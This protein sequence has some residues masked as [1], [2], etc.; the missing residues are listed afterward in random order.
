L[1]FSG[2]RT[3]ELLGEIATGCERLVHRSIREPAARLH[4]RRLI[5]LL[6]A[7]P[8]PVAVSIALTFPAQ[9]D[10]TTMLGAVC[11]TFAAGWL[12]ALAVMAT[13]RTRAVEILALVAGAGSA[14]AIVAAAGGLSS[15]A[16]LSIVALP[17]EAWWL[18]RSSKATLIGAAAGLAVIPV[19]AALGQSLPV[20]PDL[21]ALG[22]FV[23]LAYAAFAAPRAAAWRNEAATETTS[24]P[25]RHLDGMIDA[26][27]LTTTGSGDVIDASPQARRLLGVAPELLLADG[28]FERIHIADRVA[29]M[30]ALADLRQGDDKR[31]VE[32]RLRT[33][34]S[35]EG[36]AAPEYRPFLIE[37]M[38]QGDAEQSII[39][40]AR[41]HQEVVRLR[42]ALAAT[43]ETAQNLE[44]DKS[45]FLA[46]VS[47]ELR[48]PLNAI[49]GFSDMLLHGLFGAFSDPR[50]KEYVGLVSESGHHL[51]AVVNSILDVSRME[52]GTYSTAPEPFRFRDAVDM[53]HSMLKHQA[54]A[55]QI[56]LTV[57]VASE[58]GAIDA[59]RG[60]V[61][62]MLINLVSNAIK[63]T[64]DGGN[65][66]IGA[67]RIGS[68]LHF[69]VSDNGIGISADDLA[70]IGKPFTQVQNDYTKRYEGAGLGLSLVTGL[71]S[72]HQGTMSIESEPGNGTTVT[73]SL[74]VD[75]PQ[76][77]SEKA[78]VVTL[79][80]STAKEDIHGTYR[81][82]G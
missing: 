72:L 17:L 71:V 30:C 43:T 10:A 59:D 38:S 78:D 39:M 75:R 22:W 46:A 32:V 57:D 35:G 81:K 50:Q 47:H 31:R 6:L 19:Q 61:Q 24:H 49:I 23:P 28:L 56:G 66:E 37:M 18:Y 21:G 82:T 41:N 53:C 80:Q 76:R 42:E 65:V 63:F 51:L 44:A 16:T 54:D 60:A 64:P 8:V 25:A 2:T 34:G 73:I 74:P 55:R 11:V 58:V 14:A 15:P 1:H 68:R 9:V 69:W 62:Q 40:V 5:G 77:T 45:H 70:R 48:T 36:S 3:E 27:V 52:A 20:H 7:G 13:G 79:P 33:P 29:Y 4:Q 12:M 26:V 67:K